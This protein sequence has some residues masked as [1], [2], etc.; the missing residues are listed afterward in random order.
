MLTYTTEN[1]TDILLK[2]RRNEYINN[3]FSLCKK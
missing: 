3:N 2:D 1:K